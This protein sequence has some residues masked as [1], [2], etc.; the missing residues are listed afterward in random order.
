[1]FEFFATSVP[2]DDMQWQRWGVLTSFSYEFHFELVTR[3]LSPDP[4]DL[5]GFFDFS[6][7]AI[8]HHGWP[9]T[10]ST[11]TKALLFGVALALSAYAQPSPDVQKR[12]SAA[13]RNAAGQSNPDYSAFVNPFIGTGAL[14]TF[15]Y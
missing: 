7:R 15:S 4:W 1:V 14:A 6:S 13:I 12:I 11:M 5:W 8:Q 3:P 9:T 2:Y 10:V